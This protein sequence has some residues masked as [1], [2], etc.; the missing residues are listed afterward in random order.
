ML[1]L[2]A[3]R[4]SNLTLGPTLL[5][6]VPTLTEHCNNGGPVEVVEVVK[7]EAIARER[8]S[9][10]RRLVVAAS[11]ILRSKKRGGGE[12]EM[13][14]KEISL[15]SPSV[16][17]GRSGVRSTV[18]SPARRARKSV[19]NR[20]SGGVVKELGFPPWRAVEGRKENGLVDVFLLPHYL[21]ILE[22][23]LSPKGI[24]I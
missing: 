23:V 22:M 21:A 17:G 6:F 9:S 10:N 3:R 20:E 24:K 7:E 13:N 5:F 19:P 16:V 12:G 2:N 18:S 11:D 8:S 4:L 15:L 1:T 14:G